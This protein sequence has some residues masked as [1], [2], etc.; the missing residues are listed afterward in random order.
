MPPPA[1]PENQSLRRFKIGVLTTGVIVICL[2]QI[3]VTATGSL[4]AMGVAPRP[5]GSISEAGRLVR[6]IGRPLVGM[7]DHPVFVSRHF[8]DF[9]SIVSLQYVPNASVDLTVDPWFPLTEDGRPGSSVSSERFWVGWAFRGIGPKV[10]QKAFEDQIRKYSAWWAVSNG[11]GLQDT[12]FLVKSKTFDAPADWQPEQLK[13]SRQSPWVQIGIARWT[14][15][16]FEYIDTC[17]QVQSKES[18][19][20]CNRS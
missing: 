4:A 12:T 8:D 15:G 18:K 10:K 14:N 7:T 20:V 6:E 2:A 16:K 9:D 17:D 13:K 3:V 19:F 11:V 5:T 1:P